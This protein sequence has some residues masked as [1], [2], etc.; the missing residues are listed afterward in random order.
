MK[1]R[2]IDYSVGFNSKQRLTLE[3]DSDFREGYEK[4]KSAELDIRLDKWREKR[5]NDANAYFHVLI[6]QIAS[7]RGVSN[8]EV[9][10]RLVVDYGAYARDVD[11]QIVGFK[12]P[13]SVDVDAIYPYTRL[14]KQVEENG[15]L[16]NCY[17]VFKRSSDMDTKEMS[18]LIEGAITEARELGIDTDT[19]AQKL[20]F[21]E[22]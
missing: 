22:I 6:T 2:I 18:R 8:D 17:L 12:L 16:F 3:L 7:A 14:Y 5:S 10:Q 21:Y 15:K 13:P 9:K 1:G 19:P 4:L 20:K 11:G